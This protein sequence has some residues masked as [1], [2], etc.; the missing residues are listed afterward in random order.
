MKC[1]RNDLRNKGFSLIELLVGLLI[2]GILMATVTSVLLMAQK[3]YT[4]GGDISYK[5]GTVTNTETNLQNLLAVATEVHLLGAPKTDD[6]ESYSIGFNTE[7]LCQEFSTTTTVDGSGNKQY[8]KTVTAVPHLSEIEVKATNNKTTILNYKLIPKDNTM[9]TLS[10]GT[11]MNNINIF[12][13]NQPELEVATQ[14]NLLN[15]NG[16]KLKESGNGQHYLVLTFKPIN[17][18]S[19]VP[20]SGINDI[21]EDTGVFVGNWD[22]LIAYAKTLPEQG[23]QFQENGEEDGSVYTDSTG[24]YVTANK[25]YVG[26]D[27]VL[28]YTTA[29]DYYN[30]F[31]PDSVGFI[32]ISETTRV[33]TADD[34]D[35]DPATWQNWKA[36]KAPRRGDLYLYKGV[37]YIWQANSSYDDCTQDPTKDVNWL[38]LISAPLQ[39]R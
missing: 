34:Y 27:Y 25:M 30:W 33:I 5:E 37:Y 2:T 4:R 12:K 19:V 32:K 17:G 38:K 13:D 35:I 28:K 8:S 31:S 7:G 36:G 26:S 18:G 21:L 16:A 14:A 11:V 23:Y 10:G 39:F 3:V 29:R 20:E 9:S 24:T 1:Q 15:E 22:K 6:E